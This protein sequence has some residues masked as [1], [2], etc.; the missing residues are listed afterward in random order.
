MSI[1]Q[2]LNGRLH[3]SWC[4]FLS[5][6][7]VPDLLARSETTEPSVVFVVESPHTCE[8]RSNERAA[9]R[10]PLAGSSGNAMT[11][12]FVA[13]GL[14]CSCHAGRPFGE[15]VRDG[16]LEWP[17]VL[18]VCELPLQADSYHQ[19]FAAGLQSTLPNLQDWGKLMVAFE[20]IR[21]Y[22]TSTSNQWPGD[23]L[24][25]EVL[26]DFQ[27]RLR[28]AVS[29][30]PLV[31]ALGGVAGAACRKAAQKERTPVSGVSPDESVPSSDNENATR[32]EPGATAPHPSRWS[33]R[34]EEEQVQR[35]FISVKAHL[36]QST[37]TEQ[38]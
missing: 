36:D 7:H 34:A 37:D 26:G 4:P 9:H 8:V 18:N 13:E 21:R 11:S 17:R 5:A 27:D 35:M 15:V 38:C 3:G 28:R 1:I 10:H 23:N 29:D 12:K 6:F 32:M 25:G 20:K 2:R 30:S 16:D 24:E 33:R 22:R 31:V 14:L 19:L